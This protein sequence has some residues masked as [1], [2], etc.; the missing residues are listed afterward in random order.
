MVKVIVFPL[1]PVRSRFPGRR[2]EDD[3]L[4]LPSTVT[5]TVT[6]PLKENEVQ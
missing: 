4:P 2:N 1:S 6:L 5:F 3:T